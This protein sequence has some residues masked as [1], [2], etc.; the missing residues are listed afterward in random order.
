MFFT[1]EPNR[2]R[3]ESKATQKKEVLYLISV[4]PEALIRQAGQTRE[5]FQEFVGEEHLPGTFVV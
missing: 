2:T 1:L 3:R 5:T 4:P